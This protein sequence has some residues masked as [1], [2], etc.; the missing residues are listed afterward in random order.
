MSIEAAESIASAQRVSLLFESAP[1]AT[2]EVDERGRILHANAEAEH[3]FQRSREE[4]LHLTI[5]ALVPER[6]RGQASWGIVRVMRL[7]R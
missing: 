2:F 3:M 5:E 6:F 1:D 7:T 4:L